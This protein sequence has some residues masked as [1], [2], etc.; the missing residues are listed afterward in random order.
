[1]QH[2][3]LRYGFEIRHYAGP[4]TYNCDEFLVKN[5]DST[6]PDT[7]AL[8]QQSK[9]EV[10]LQLFPKEEEEP[11]TGRGTR[12]RKPRSKTFHT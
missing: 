2:K 7:M 10:V 1:M 9:D 6:D 4:V 11:D 3:G 8:F 12:R 5:N